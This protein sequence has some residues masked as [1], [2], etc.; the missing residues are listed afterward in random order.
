MR[1]GGG[2]DL[3]SHGLLLEVAQGDVT[4]DIPVE[5]NEDGVEARHR[6]E[7]LGDVIMRL[8]LGGVGVEGQ[9]QCVLDEA[10]GIGLPVH[11]RVGG[12]V[13]VVVTDGT[14]DLAQQRYCLD[15]GDL[16]LQSIHHVGHLLAQCGRGSRLAVGT[17]Q[18]GNISKLYGQIADLVG[19]PAHHW[20]YHFVTPGAQHEGMGQVVDVLGGAGEVDELGDG[21]QFGQ[22]LGLFLQQI[23]HRFDVMVGGAFDFLD[24][25]GMAQL[26]VVYQTVEQGIGLGGERLDLGDARMGSQTLQPTHLN[27][28]A[29]AEQTIF[30]EDTAQ[31]GS[32]AAVTAINGRYGSQ[33]GQLHG[34]SHL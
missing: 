22:G 11:L 10:A 12:Q 30:T 13:G 17:G 1:H 20:Q 23:L 33:G 9:P 25:L 21:I 3:A 26:E 18:H 19:N 14:I 32:L 15:L 24:A 31:G 8:D 29:E 16:T 34:E 28:Y 4:P 6:V 2:A 7:E 5:I 27:L